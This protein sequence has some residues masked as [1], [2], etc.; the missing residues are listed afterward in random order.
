MI[1]GT[2][3]DLNTAITDSTNKDVTVVM[4]P[5]RPLTLDNDIANGG[6]KARNI[7]FVGDGTQTVDVITNAT[8]AEGGQLN[9][10][11]GSTFTF[12]NVT[13]QA[14]EGQLRR[15]RLRRAGLSQ[16]H[17]QGQADSVRQGHLHQLYL[18]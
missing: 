12:E 7:T 9:Y 18:R 11:R 15:H 8:G 4:P 10:Q 6:A 16:L 17:H 5:T 14:G 13:V 2:Q 3:E 1:P